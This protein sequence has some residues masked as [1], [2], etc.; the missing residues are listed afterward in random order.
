MQKKAI[1]PIFLGFLLLGQTIVMDIVLSY[2]Q[3]D[4]ENKSQ[5][6]TNK[7]QFYECRIDLKTINCQPLHNKIVRYFSGTAK[8]IYDPSQ[9]ISDGISPSGS[10][11]VEPRAK[12]I[13]KLPNN[14][15]QFIAVTWDGT[16]LKLYRNGALED[17]YPR[18]GSL[19]EPVPA[20]IGSGEQESIRGSYWRGDMDEIRIY[21]RSL[22]QHEII[23]IF[24]ESKDVL[25]GIVGYW[26]FDGNTND[27]SGNNNHGNY[28]GNKAEFVDGIIGNAL[29][30]DGDD[31]VSL[32]S[33]PA[34]SEALSFTAWIKLNTEALDNSREIF[35]NNQF[36]LRVDPQSEA[37]NRVSAFVKLLKNRPDPYGYHNKGLIV[38]MAFAPDGRLFFTEKNTGNVRIMKDDKVLETPFVAISNIYTLSESGLLGLTLDPNF[39]ENHFV[40]LYHT[41]VDEKTGEPFN[42]V[43][44][45][46]DDNS[47][48]TDMKVLIDRI[49]AN[50]VGAHSGGALAFGPDEKLYITV[51]DNLEAESSQD[52]SILTGKILRINRDGTI[53]D[54][55]PWL[56]DSNPSRIH[57]NEVLDENV[58]CEVRY[59]SYCNFSIRNP[60]VAE[61]DDELIRTNNKFIVEKDFEVKQSNQTSIKFTVNNPSSDV[62]FYRDYSKGV[63]GLNLERERDWTRYNYLTFWVNGSNDNSILGVRIR[64]SNWDDRYEEY[65]IRN[66]FTGWK[67]FMIPLKDTYPSMD[68]SSVRGIEFVFHRGWNAT[69]NLDAVY[70]ANSSDPFVERKSYS[71][72]SPVYT[73][74]HRNMFGIA[75]D[76]EGI[77]IVTENGP[78]SYDEI[79]K[80]ERAGNYGWPTHQPPN[81]APELSKS[82]IKPLT[83]YLQNI[84]PTQAIY[85]D[86]DENPEL[87]GKFLFG[88]Y[89]RG[90]L[91]AL[92]FDKGSEEIIYEEVISTN[93]TGPLISLAQSP[94]GSLYYAGSAIYKLEKVVPNYE[95]Q[96][97]FPIEITGPV[98]VKD[99]QLSKDKKKMVIDINTRESSSVV[100][101]KIPKFLLDGIFKVTDSK[102]QVD[103]TVNDSSPDYNIVNISVTK[104]DSKLEI[105]GTMVI[106]E[107]PVAIMVAFGAVAIMLVTTRLKRSILL[108]VQL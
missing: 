25:N 78:E 32:P 92:S 67:S 46:T 51:G 108:L 50:N 91:Y 52:P 36:F 15:W 70:V 20:N 105:F 1:L 77:G 44:R 13:S 47:R 97:L 80:I 33:Q 74:G 73:I 17:S 100:A 75:F 96:V 11:S 43:V 19:V 58:I 8:L 59:R 30:F 76:N 10:I 84:V 88:S 22:T 69:I 79:N 49:P 101:F 63:G 18:I 83:S 39:A 64:D 106:P 62:S 24:T 40:Y 104:G 48:S 87:K 54:D 86:G 107:F 9:V 41:S 71:Y 81:V 55:N 53:P 102:Q 5:H 98:D 26:T 56:W 21:N 7:K 4:L 61:Y 34:F 23:Q 2:S 42:R 60:M 29:R 37:P 68:F 31:H 93:H 65:S 38:S 89:F 6:P 27:I 72:V 28:R 12:S 3:R 103:F 16:S 45:F 95:E 82:S 14:E 57:S 85:Y 66:N 94:D 35:N 99:L 90:N